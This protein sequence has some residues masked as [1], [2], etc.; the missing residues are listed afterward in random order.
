MAEPKSAETEI[1]E[2]RPKKP[3]KAAKGK[4]NK[5]ASGKK[6]GKAIG[7]IVLIALIALVGVAYYFNLLGLKTKVVDFFLM[8]DTEY[9]TRLEEFESGKQAMETQKAAYEQK[10]ADLESKANSLA[11][12][13]K[14]LNEREVALVEAEKGK[15][16]NTGTQTNKDGE[17]EVTASQLA[18]VYEKMDSKDAATILNTVADNGWIAALFSQMNEKKVAGIMAALET[19]KAAI[20]SRL[21][22]E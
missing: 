16:G 8:Q 11:T 4:K 10:L 9:S 19:E 7:A 14:Q 17:T 15:A 13:E 2:K 20:I 22:S 5:K 1:Q 6:K 21:M 18:L 3:T 12:K